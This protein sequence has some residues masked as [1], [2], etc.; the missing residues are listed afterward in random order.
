MLNADLFRDR[1]SQL[2]KIIL[3]LCGV[4]FAIAFTGQAW[5][6]KTLNDTLIVE[7]AKLHKQQA[8]NEQLQAKVDFLKDK[9]FSAYAERAARD[10][11]HMARPGD[12]YVFVVPHKVAAT[13][14]DSVALPKTAAPPPQQQVPE[15]VW[16]QWLSVFFP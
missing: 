16:K 2:A 13:P 11:L 7:Q 5:K 15:P 4:Y 8:Y 14:S 3:L 10:K 9:G 6:A 12:H 1:R